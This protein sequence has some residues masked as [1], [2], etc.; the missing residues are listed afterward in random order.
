M[1]GNF[2]AFLKH[3]IIPVIAIDNALHADPLGDALVEAGLP[4]AEITFRTEAATEAIQ[5]MSKK[6]RIVVGAGT[7][8]NIDQAQKAMDCGASFIVSPG[9]NPKV[10]SYC[11]KKKVPVYPGVSN[12][13]DIEMALDHGLEVVK[14]FPA[15]ACGGLK[16]LNAMSA[17]YHMM[18]FIPTGGIVPSNLLAY[19]QHSKVPACGGSWMVTSKLIADQCFE[20]ITRL[21]REAVAIV[22]QAGPY[23]LKKA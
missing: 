13:T 3:R 21:A 7:V 16:L 22:Q 18:K 14:F 15:E 17:P 20:D 12:P 4:I 1:D 23:Q 5:I 11:L 9:F 6:E 19:L 2:F 10:V 8:L